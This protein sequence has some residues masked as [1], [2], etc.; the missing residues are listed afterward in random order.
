MDVGGHGVNLELKAKRS[1]HRRLKWPASS[2]VDEC[3]LQHGILISDA[4]TLCCTTSDLR[5]QMKS[6]CRPKVRSRFAGEYRDNRNYG[7]ATALRLTHL[8]QRC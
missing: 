5:H 1:F 6:R 4:R 7:S 8:W 2:A 3:H